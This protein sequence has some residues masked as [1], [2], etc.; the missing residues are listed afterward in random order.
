MSS[1]PTKIQV[2]TEVKTAVLAYWHDKLSLEAESLSSLRYMKTRYLA[3]TSCHPIFRTC[4]SSSWSVDKA[5]CQARLFSGRA[6]FERLTRHLT[7]LNKE[8]LCTLPQCWGTHQSHQGTLESFLLSCP[9]LTQARQYLMLFTNSA[10]TANP[11]ITELVKKCLILNR[12]Q[13]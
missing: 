8:G 12:H 10:I 3:L 4:G 7:P 9:S 2:K 11:R 13:F 1:Q 5:I 6:K